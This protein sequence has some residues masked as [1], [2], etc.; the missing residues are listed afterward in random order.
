MTDGY[1]RGEILVSEAAKVSTKEEM[2]RRAKGLAATE[3]QAVMRSVRTQKNWEGCCLCEG[4]VRCKHDRETNRSTKDIVDSI[5]NRGE[6]MT[7]P[8]NKWA[9]SKLFLHN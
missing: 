4:C 7:W 3:T 2:G 6:Q 9:G 1:N 5:A 8:Q